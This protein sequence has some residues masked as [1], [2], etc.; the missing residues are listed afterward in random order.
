VLVNQGADWE[1]GPLYGNLISARLHEARQEYKEALA[2]LRRRDKA[3][4]W[5]IVVTYHREEGRIAAEAGDTARAIRAYERY[6]RIRDDAE[7]RLQPEV[8]RVR[9]ELVAL[10]HAR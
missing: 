10:L 8:Q 9:A 6:L 3:F 4:F 7:P 2:A 1:N 5:P